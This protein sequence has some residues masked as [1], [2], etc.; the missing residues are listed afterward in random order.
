MA[1]AKK[2]ETKKT[3]PKAKPT[4][5]ASEPANPALIPDEEITLFDGTKVSKKD[6]GPFIL[7]EDGYHIAGNSDLCKHGKF[8]MQLGRKDGGHDDFA[9][10]FRKTEDGCLIFKTHTSED[11]KDSVHTIKFGSGESTKEQKVVA[12]GRGNLEKAAIVFEIAMNSVAEQFGMLGM[13]SV[14]RVELDHKAKIWNAVCASKMDIL[15]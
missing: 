6:C 12:I 9:I 7:K 1:T 15:V 10:D 3:A 2:N 11:L 14:V 8:V 13:F 4:T 5:T